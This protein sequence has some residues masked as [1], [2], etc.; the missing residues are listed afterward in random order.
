MTAKLATNC[1]WIAYLVL[2]WMCELAT[3]RWSHKS[4][5][6]LRE[7]ELG[8]L[9]SSLCCTRLSK[10]R[11][12]GND[13]V[14]C[15]RRGPR[16]RGVD[17]NRQAVEASIWEHMVVD[18]ACSYVW[19]GFRVGDPIPEGAVVGGDL[20]DG[21]P[22]NVVVTLGAIGRRPIGYYSPLTSTFCAY[23]LFPISY[24]GTAGILVNV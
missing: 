21:T 7:R 20:A 5:S 9:G 19:V 15:W 24:S 22:L 12:V 13:L 17:T 2:R 16:S 10:W 23:W 11:S 14:T 8:K 18:P 6:F 1:L 3:S 4:R